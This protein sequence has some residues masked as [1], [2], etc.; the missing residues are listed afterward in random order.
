MKNIDHLIMMLKSDNLYRKIV[1]LE[2]GL[3]NKISELK[4]LTHYINVGTT[5]LEACD[6]LSNVDLI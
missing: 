3:N 1:E 5:N 4:L 6:T 2:N